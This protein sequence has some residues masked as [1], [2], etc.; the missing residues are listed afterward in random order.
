MLDEVRK[1][2]QANDE[3]QAYTNTLEQALLSFRGRAL[4]A[5]GA[6]DAAGLDP[7]IQGWSRV[8]HTR[9]ESRGTGKPI[10]LWVERLGV[11][12]HRPGHDLDMMY[13]NIPL[14]GDFQ[15]DCEL[16]RSPGQRMRVFYGGVAVAPTDDPKMLER[17]RLGQ[18]PLEVAITPPLEKLGEWYPLRLVVSGG[19]MTVS[20]NGQKVS[21]NALPAESDPWLALVCRAGETASARSIKITGSPRIPEKLNLSATP[22]LA[23]WLANEYG[24]VSIDEPQWDQRGDE[25]TARLNENS[26]GGKEESVLRYHRPLLED[27]RIEY[28]FYHDPGKVMV[29][30]AVDRLAFLLDPSGMKVHRLTDG[31]FERSGLAPD[32]VCDEPESR[33]GSGPIPLKP[34]AW[35]HLALHL[36]GDVVT[37]ELNGQVVFERR[38]EPENQRTFGLF[39]YSD[40]TQ[41]RVRKVT[42]QGGWARA[43][44]ENLG[45]GGK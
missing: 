31:A 28:E 19:R 16:S 1:R 26:A 12:T 18:P 2:N 22:G 45:A 15:L 34:Q 39:H 17:F 42:Y 3:F 43:L 32:N 7:K 27:G 25:I 10:A 33:R 36:K 5:A 30:P 35:N 44:P 38:L 14:R 24:E 23:S 40:E 11:L 13:L 9:A 41:V 20:V 29:H 6:K 21:E 4:A 8:T 37:I